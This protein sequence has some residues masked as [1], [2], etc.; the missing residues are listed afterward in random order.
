MMS[1]AKT[2]DDWF[3]NLRLDQLYETL[4]RIPIH[5]YMKDRQSR[6]VYANRKTLELFGCRAEE[7]CGQDDAAFFPADTA[8]HLRT[9]DLKVLGGESTFEEIVAGDGEQQRVYLEVKTPIYDRNEPGRVLG[10]LGISTDITNQKH[11]ENHIRELAYSDPLTQLPNR[12][13]LFDRIEHA[14]ARCVREQNHSALLFIDLNG[15]KQI[16]DG[17]GHEIGDR[18]LEE[19]AARILEQVRQTDTLARL[20]GDEFVLLIEGAGKQAFRA[21][22]YVDMVG[23]RIHAALEEPFIF[24]DVSVVTSAAIGITL[25]N[26]DTASVSD[27]LN[28]A[29]SEMYRHKHNEASTRGASAARSS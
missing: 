3:R 26:D 22:R 6:Y 4:D 27:L 11:L 23:A 19:V 10:L 2:S 20:G 12:R 28:Q 9:V 24:G 29:D 13:L 5:V 17:F 14:Q 21:R 1:N 25:F 7:L 8:R 16:N 18:L 15:F